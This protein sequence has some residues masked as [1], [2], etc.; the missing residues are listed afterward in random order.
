ME[1]IMTGHKRGGKREGAGAPLKHK[2]PTKAMTFRFPESVV[3][4]IKEQPNATEYLLNFVKKD[5]EDSEPT[6]G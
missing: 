6:A 5:M 2:E 3:K 4:H 1:E